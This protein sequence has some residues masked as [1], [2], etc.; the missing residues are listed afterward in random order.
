V[1]PFTN[2]AV[3]GGDER[4]M[5][6]PRAYVMCLQ[7][8]AIKPALQRLMLERAGCDPVIEIDTDHLV[9]ASRPDE[10]AAALDRLA[11]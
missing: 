3:L 8:R 4:F 9:W 1:A 5:E 11:T 2:P 7:D 6:L 10:L